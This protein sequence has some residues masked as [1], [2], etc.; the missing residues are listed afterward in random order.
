[1][2]EANREKNEKNDFNF[3]LSRLFRSMRA[4][5]PFLRC[6][7][8]MMCHPGRKLDMHEIISHP[9]LLNVDHCILNKLIKLDT[10][11]IRRQ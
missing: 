9:S 6:V 5:L 3:V 10:A 8:E 1:M 7:D 11:K 4:G 2:A